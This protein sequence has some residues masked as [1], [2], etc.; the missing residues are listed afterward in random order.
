M[1][2]DSTKTEKMSQRLPGFSSSLFRFIFLSILRRERD[3]TRDT[4]LSRCNPTLALF[5]L[6]CVCH[7]S[8]NV[9][10]AG[11]GETRKRITR[12]EE[13]FAFP[14]IILSLSRR[15][16]RFVRTRTNFPRE[17][18]GRIET[19]FLSSAI[20]RF[21]ANPLLSLSLFFYFLALLDARLFPV[22]YVAVV[23]LVP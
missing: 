14:Q 21:L 19:S 15:D 12:A 17:I 22:T 10:T 6:P 13:R 16:G 4:Y 9:T 7:K 8:G 1:T 5:L 3:F 2:S 18:G 11:E 20:A 23:Q